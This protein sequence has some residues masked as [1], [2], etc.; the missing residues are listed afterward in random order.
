M[1]EL[2][3]K[4]CNG[5]HYWDDAGCYVCALQQEVA[6]LEVRLTSAQRQV[7]ALENAART[8]K[9]VLESTP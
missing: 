2:C 9:Q 5:G 1:S 7:R 6:R 3:E 8:R 4:H